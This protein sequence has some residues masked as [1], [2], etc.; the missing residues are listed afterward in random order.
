MRAESNEAG[1]RIIWVART[2]MDKDLIVTLAA[3][4]AAAFV[5]NNRVAVGDVPLVIQRIYD[6]LTGLGSP[7]E[8]PPIEIAPVVPVRSSVK[9]DF[10]LCL[11]CGKK[12]KTL[13]RHISFAHGLDEM[14]YRQ[15][16]NL[17]QSYPMVAPGYSETRKALAMKIGLGTAGRTNG[18]GVKVK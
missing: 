14:A 1:A 15:K 8:S 17:P 6:S 2:V 12:S 5:S 18:F 9:Q 16:F 11:Q 10:I 13:R 4:V 3:D 7:L